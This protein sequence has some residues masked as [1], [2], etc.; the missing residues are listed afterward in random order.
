MWRHDLL[1]IHASFI[2]GLNHVIPSKTHD[3]IDYGPIVM[4]V[5]E[6]QFCYLDTAVTIILACL[7]S[8]LIFS[9]NMMIW[10][11]F[12]VLMLHCT[13]FDC[14]KRFLPGLFWVRPIWLIDSILCEG[15][16]LDT[17][18]SCCICL[19]W[20]FYVISVILQCGV[21]SR[22]ISYMTF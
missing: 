12:W 2:F 10:H 17:F 5:I 14:Q 19:L 6:A 4:A 9:W 20:K 11:H 8:F 7:L 21:Y 13:W 1:L 15:T 3:P 22:S 16:M 18:Q